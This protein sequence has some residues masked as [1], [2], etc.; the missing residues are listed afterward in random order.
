VGLNFPPFHRRLIDASLDMCQE[1]GL[2]LAGGYAMKAH[3]LVDRPSSDL[4]FAT[5]NP[6][7]VD[8]LTE[9]AVNRY[10]VQGFNVE[11]TPGNYRFSRLRVSDP[12]TGEASEVDL[13]KA[14]L[15]VSPIT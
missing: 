7:P 11:V 1:Y 9:L 3:G 12:Q 13:M 8:R 6:L 2:F 15:K 5:P 14:E 4:D 10:W